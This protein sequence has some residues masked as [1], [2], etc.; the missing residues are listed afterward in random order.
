[1][2]IYKPIIALTVN[3]KYC[4]KLLI[5]IHDA[6][7]RL[8]RIQLQWGWDWHARVSVWVEVE[9]ADVCREF[10][11]IEIE[12]RH[13]VVS[14]SVSYILR[15]IYVCVGLGKRDQWEGKIAIL[16]NMATGNISLFNNILKLFLSSSQ[17]QRE[18]LHN[19][20]F[21]PPLPHQKLF[22]FLHTVSRGG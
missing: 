8:T 20:H 21:P 19:Y 13:P 18:S 3:I 10:E 15:L 11:Q 5:S 6:S 17:S 1:M 7:L 4:E 16:R 9:W 12:R 14:E 2:L 22:K